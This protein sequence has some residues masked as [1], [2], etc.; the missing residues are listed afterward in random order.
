MSENMRNFDLLSVWR[1]AVAVWARHIVVFSALSSVS[2]FVLMLL[3]AARDAMG[4]LTSYGSGSTLFLLVLFWIAAHGF[5]TL[6]IIGHYRRFGRGEE[7]A[8]GASF[9]EACRGWGAYFASVLMLLGLAVF[10]LAMAVVLLEA[11]RM[12]YVIGRENIVLLVGT[13]LAAVLFV[14]ATGW[15]GF[16]FSLAP[17]VAAYESQPALEAFRRSRRRIRGRALPYM[18]TLSLFV[19]GYMVV[20]LGLYFGLKALGA[21]RPLLAWVDP[22]MVILFSPLWLALWYTCYERLAQPTNGGD[23]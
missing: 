14:I 17:L 7:Q 8:F 9:S 20:G 13:H 15:Y 19:F 12:L 1:Q 10:G 22:A 11:G 23:V 5:V 3:R 2:Y 18:A 21:G 6:L 16:Y 4:G